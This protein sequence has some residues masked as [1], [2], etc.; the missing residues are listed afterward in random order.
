MRASGRFIIAKCLRQHLGE[1][2]QVD[3]V[4]RLGRHAFTD[5]LEDTDR[6]Q[7]T[8]RGLLLLGAHPRLG[9]P[10]VDVSLLLFPEPS[11][12]TLGSRRV[13]QEQRLAQENGALHRHPWQLGEHRLVRHRT[14]Q[15]RRKHCGRDAHAI[16][17]VL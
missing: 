2:I 3:P 6:H 13:A 16:P 15:Q 12:T 9:F 8:P 11:T 7:L 17:P 4:P 1:T 14:A 5:L 10:A